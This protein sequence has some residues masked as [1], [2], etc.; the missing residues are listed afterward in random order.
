M[1]FLCLRAKVSGTGTGS[2]TSELLEESYAKGASKDQRRV[3]KG[4]AGV[5]YAGEFNICVTPNLLI[6]CSYVRVIPGGSDTVSSE[7]W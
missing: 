3:I 1:P 4:V 6:L 7:S 2:L 5:A